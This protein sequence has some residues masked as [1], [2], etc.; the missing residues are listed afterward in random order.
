VRPADLV[1][2]HEIQQLKHRYLRT[3]DGKDWAGFRE[4]FCADA[5]AA[6]GDRLTFTG[7]D[8]IVAFMADNLGPTMITMHQVHQPEIAVDGTEATGTW[9]L[10]DRVIMTEHRLLLEGCS[11]YH[12]RYRLEG[13]TWRIAHTSYLRQFEHVVSMDDL[14]SFRL[15]ANRFAP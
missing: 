8:E 5:T 9:S 11:I 13:G 14:P 3:L 6:Y 2:I 15:T 10:Q 12:D 7:V 1:T 4:V